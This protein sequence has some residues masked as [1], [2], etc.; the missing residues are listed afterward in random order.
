MSHSGIPNI[1]ERSIN[2]NLFDTAQ[3]NSALG[4]A[5]TCARPLS[6]CC[7]NT[8][9]SDVVPSKLAIKLRTACPYMHYYYNLII[10]LQLCIFFYFYFHNSSTSRKCG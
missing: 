7:A 10:Y 5:A 9:N 4:M 8:R 2:S 1:L 6:I 3:T